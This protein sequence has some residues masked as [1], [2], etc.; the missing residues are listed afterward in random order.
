MIN[1]LCTGVVNCFRKT[2]R[3]VGV[4]VERKRER[5]RKRGRERKRKRGRERGRKRVLQGMQTSAITTNP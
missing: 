2:K 4:R 3:V 5:E 1:N